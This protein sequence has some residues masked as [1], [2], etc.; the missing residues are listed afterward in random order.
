MVQLRD[1]LWN[2]EPVG[3][4]MLSLIQVERVFV[5]QKQKIYSTVSVVGSSKEEDDESV[6]VAN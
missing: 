5:P 6:S 4:P 1:P 3:T 2:Y